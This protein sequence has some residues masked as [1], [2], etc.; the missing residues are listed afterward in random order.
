MEKYIKDM[1]KDGCYADH[2]AIT[3]ASRMLNATITTVHQSQDI[4]IGEY[5]TIL[6]VGYIPELNHYVSA[7][8]IRKPGGQLHFYSFKIFV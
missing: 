7:V 1:S 4:T 6:Y 2:I 5:I 8:R 3:C